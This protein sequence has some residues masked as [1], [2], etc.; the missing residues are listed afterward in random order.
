MKPVDPRLVRR[1]P[2]LRR[3]LAVGGLLAVAGA[4]STVL[5]AV[6]VATVLAGLIATP[7]RSSAGQLG[8]LAAALAVRIVVVW[9][10]ARLADRAADRVIGEL[11]HEVLA[12][13]TALPPRLLD[14]HRVP[15][16]VLVTTGLA[17]LRPYLSGYLPALLAALVVPPIIVAALMFADPASALIVLVTLPL[18]PVFMILIGLLTRGRAAAALA[19]MTRLSG[20]TADLVAGLPTLRALD[21]AAG[22]VGLIRS[23]GDSYRHTTIRALRLAF[24]SALVLE[25][26]ATLSVAL[27][28]VGVG[29]R[30]VFGAMPLQAALLALLLAPEAYLPLRTLGERFHAAE[31]GVAAVDSAFELLETYPARVPGADRPDVP[32]GVLEWRDVSVSG[33]DGAAPSGLTAVARPGRIT[34]L[35]GANGAGKSTALQVL[36]GL[37]EP[38]TGCAVVDGVPLPA[39]DLDWWWRRVAWLPQRPTVVAGRTEPLDRTALSLGQRQRRALDAVLAADTPVL[40]LDEPTAHLDDASEAVVLDRLRARARAGATVVIVGHR[41]AVLAAADAVVAVRDG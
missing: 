10:Q 33:R 2:A 22:P 21:R 4:G 15:A 3:Y 32:L 11:E 5:A 14:R 6:M 41:P 30:L 27:V 36:L 20:R 19:S 34:A 9:A 38:D 25:L 23:L 35:T 29:L 12:T 28:A 39:L 18:I 16:S 26:L 8:V 1:S 17:A 31:D 24:L 37:T 13:V 7:G 40:L